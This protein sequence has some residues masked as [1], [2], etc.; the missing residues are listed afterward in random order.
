MSNKCKNLFFYAVQSPFVLCA[1]FALISLLFSSCSLNISD[2]PPAYFY[3]LNTD[4]PIGSGG[5]SVSFFR[6]LGYD[7]ETGTVNVYRWEDGQV[8]LIPG[9]DNPGLPLEY[10]GSFYVLDGDSICCY[11]P[12]NGEKKA[13][14]EIQGDSVEYFWGKN[15]CLYLLIYTFSDTSDTTYMIYRYN[16]AKESLE[17]L[18]W[19]EDY[20]AENQCTFFLQFGLFDNELACG[21]GNEESETKAFWLNVDDGSVRSYNI[22][23]VWYGTR[24]GKLAVY[25]N[26]RED[27]F[28]IDTKT[29]RYYPLDLP[30]EAYEEEYTLMSVGEDAAYF[31]SGYNFYVYRNGKLRLLLSYKGIPVTD[32]YKH[33]RFVGDT[34]YFAF[35]GTPDDAANI[36]DLAPDYDNK[37]MVY[38]C[39]ADKTD[40]VFILAKEEYNSQM[41]DF[42]Y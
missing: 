9:E 2:E 1:V 19:I 35:V 30:S 24:D 23:G 16:L 42:G 20:K 22:N 25:D 6:T 7:Y 36:T 26:E 33:H 18:S 21:M 12:A 41:Q 11:N 5:D 29:G 3:C 14:F 31:Q 40:Q 8:S 27:F 10:D 28:L 34:F 13:L 37:R 38:Y 15:G 32:V 39:A 17:I 4:D